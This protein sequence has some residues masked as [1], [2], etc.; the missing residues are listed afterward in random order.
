MCTLNS[1]QCVVVSG[2][3]EPREI[4]TSVSSNSD[5]KLIGDSKVNKR[6]YYYVNAILSKIVC[7]ISLNLLLFWLITNNSMRKSH[8]CVLGTHVHFELQ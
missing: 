4:R 2:F 3:V 6:M 1:V 7:I 5:A 8:M